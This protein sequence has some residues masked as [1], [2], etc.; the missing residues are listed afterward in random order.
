MLTHKSP[1]MSQPY[2]HLR[3]EALNAGADQVD[4]IFNKQAVRRNI[5]RFQADFKFELSKKEWM[6]C[7][8]RQASDLE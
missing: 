1:V 4:D 2:A 5:Q 7:G 3:D 8:N 6:N